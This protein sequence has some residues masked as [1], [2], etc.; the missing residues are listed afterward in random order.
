MA[1]PKI[2]GFSGST[3]EGSFN[4]KLVKVALAGAAAAG[5]ET[6]FIDL[7]DFAMPMF[8]E[9]VEKAGIPQGVTQFREL[10]KSHHGLLI[11]SPEY[12]GSVSAVLKNAID[13]ATRTVGN[14]APLSCFNGK[15]AGLMA[16]S[17]GGLGGIRGLAHIRAILGGIKVL[18]IPDQIAL[19]KAHE[20]FDAQGNMVDEKMRAAVHGI[21][22]SVS[23]IVKRLA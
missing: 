16:T 6:T 2:L 7:R 14:E 23:N 12:N 17:P 3:R 8:D 13:W 22:A 15:V 21:G 4:K 19:P 20:A 10:M 5:A 1:T 11:A 9:D 18:V